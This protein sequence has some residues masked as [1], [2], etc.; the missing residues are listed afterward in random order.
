MPKLTETA[1]GR[2]TLSLIISAIVIIVWLLMTANSAILFFGSTEFMIAVFFVILSYPVYRG[3]KIAIVFSII[4][5][6]LLLLRA[7]SIYFSRQLN[8]FG[9]IKSIDGMWLS[10]V[11][12]IFMLLLFTRAYREKREIV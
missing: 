7:I 2:A 1:C 5:W 4:P 8:I 11:L 3:K 12:Y 10:I 9:K 6:T